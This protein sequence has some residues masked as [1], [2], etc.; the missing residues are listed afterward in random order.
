[1]S[2]RR[3]EAPKGTGIKRLLRR[4][5][6]YAYYLTTGPE[7]YKNRPRKKQEVVASVYSPR[8]RPSAIRST[9]KRPPIYTM[10]SPDPRAYSRATRGVA[11]SL[12]WIN[13]DRHALLNLV[14]RAGGQFV[15]NVDDIR[16]EFQLDSNGFIGQTVIFDASI[17]RD[18]GIPVNATIDQLD[19]QL[20]AVSGFKEAAVPWYSDQ[21]LPFDVTLAGT[22]EMGAAATMKIFGVEVLN[23]GFGTSVDDA[24][25]EIH[26][27]FVARMV[28]PIFSGGSRVCRRDSARQIILGALFR[29]GRSSFWGAA[30]S[31]SVF[32]IYYLGR[33]FSACRSVL[34]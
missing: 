22:N 7:L 10:G 9:A 14:R 2:W 11:G 1:M 34:K 30:E 25:S 12:I 27:T 21:I 19:T 17:T 4:M 6:L 26:A 24:V 5:N 28:E 8:S 23:E 32:C 31:N 18:S 13:F 3:R 29:L 15:A 33:R 20:T 16:P